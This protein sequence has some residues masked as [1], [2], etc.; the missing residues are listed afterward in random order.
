MIEQPKP[1]LAFTCGNNVIETHEHTGQFKKWRTLTRMKQKAAMLGGMTADCEILL[2]W[3]S[4]ALGIV[5]HLRR[6][7]ACI[8]LRTHF[9]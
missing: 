8:K 3:A 5:D 7:F 1:S 4:A 9:L 2:Y 6:R